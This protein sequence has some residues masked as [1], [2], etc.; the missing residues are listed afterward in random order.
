MQKEVLSSLLVDICVNIEFNDYIKKLS[1]NKID[2]DMQYN[3]NINESQI[4]ELN[5]IGSWHPG[6]SLTI[7]SSDKIQIDHSTVMQ[8]QRQHVSNEIYSY[9]QSFHPCLNGCGAIDLDGDILPCPSF[10]KN[11][12]KNNYPNIKDDFINL[13]YLADYWT[14]PQRNL[15]RCNNCE[16][17]SYCFDCRAYEELNAGFEPNNVGSCTK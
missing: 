9:F 14:K 3:I 1:N 6:L 2:K 8:F 7:Y 17:R 10:S 5:S 11:S 16:N 13:S 12:I 15:H 4:N